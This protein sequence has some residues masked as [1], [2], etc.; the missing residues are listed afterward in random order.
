MAAFVSISG[1]A[2]N[3]GT[4]AAAVSA[5]TSGQDICVQTVVVTAS[6]GIR[7]RGGFVERVMSARSHIMRR[8]EGG[9]GIVGSA[10]GITQ[11]SAITI[12]ISQVVLG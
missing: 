5:S 2:A 9:R 4:A 6:V 11:R 3:A 10:G 8:V 7:S 1:R 12:G